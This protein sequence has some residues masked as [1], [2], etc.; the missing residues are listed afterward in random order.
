MRCF[1]P[2]SPRPDIIDHAP[3]PSGS[4]LT[5]RSVAA[6]RDAVKVMRQAAVGACLATLANDSWAMRY[7]ASPAAAD[8][9]SRRPLT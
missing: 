9:S 4:S 8:T 3:G 1:I 7:R 5:A 6:L 2:C